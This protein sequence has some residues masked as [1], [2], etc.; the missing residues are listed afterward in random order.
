MRV[1]PRCVA[2][3]AIRQLSRQVEKRHGRDVLAGCQ[4][5]LRAILAESAETPWRLDMSELFSKVLRYSNQVKSGEKPEQQVICLDLEYSSHRGEVFEIG[6]VDYFSGEVICDTKVKQSHHGTDLGQTTPGIW[7]G[8]PSPNRPVDFKSYNKV[9]HLN[10]G[11][12]PILDVHQIADLLRSNVT[13]ETIVLVWAVGRLDLRLLRN[14]IAR[15]SYRDFLPPDE[16]CIPM[17]PLVRRELRDRKLSKKWLLH[18][19]AEETKG[20]IP[21]SLP[22]IFPLIFVGHELVGR[23]HRAIVDAMQLRLMVQYLENNCRSPEDRND[24][25]FMYR[26][27]NVQT[28]LDNS[29]FSGL[30]LID[31]SLA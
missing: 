30:S 20:T 16:N 10:A 24:G 26:W 4:E 3:S 11:T 15:V 12:S 7:T 25:L 8:S 14:L 22:V 6:V 21:L 28:K 19:S 17:I 5:S 29:A 23:N 18:E 1:D 13:P 2:C 9:F 31:P 27:T